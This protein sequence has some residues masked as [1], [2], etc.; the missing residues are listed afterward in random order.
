VSRGKI[1]LEVIRMRRRVRDESLSERLERMSCP[2]PNTGC[3]LWL[4]ATNAKGYGKFEWNRQ[5]VMPHRASFVVHFGDI[6][7]GMVVCHRCDQPRCIE[8]THLFAGTY[9][10][11]YEDMVA[12]GRRRTA[13]GELSGRSKLTEADVAAVKFRVSM[14]ECMKSV[15]KSLGVGRTTIHNAVNGITWRHLS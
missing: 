7:A 14:G 5:W 10:D 12:K 6:Q 3:R 4:G 11:N 8:S 2:E 13:Q 1:C 15:A 9:K